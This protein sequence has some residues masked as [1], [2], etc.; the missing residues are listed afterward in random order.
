MG[1][2]SRLILVLSV[3]LIIPTALIIISQNAVPGDRTY[4]IK[5]GIEGTIASLASLTP[6]TRAFF[7]VDLTDR[8]Y[9][10]AVALIKKGD[11]PTTSLSELVTQTQVAA[12][13]INTVS[14]TQ[15]KKQLVAS[16]TKQIDEYDQGLANFGQ[17]QSPLFLTPTTSVPN[18]IVPPSGL[19]PTPTPVLIVMQ[20]TTTPVPIHSTIVTPTV[21]QPVVTQSLAVVT[22]TPTVAPTPTPSIVE[23]TPAQTATD[24]EQTRQQLKKIRDDLLANMDQENEGQKHQDENKKNSDSPRQRE[25]GG[26]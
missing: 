26:D 1:M 22:P 2:L 16:L 24:V 12:Q 25:K 14:D 11:N 17:E 20:P 8:R 10:E 15:T 4:P 6:Q 3:I 18:V 13:D 19:T 9:K 7:S 21:T 23:T 5:R